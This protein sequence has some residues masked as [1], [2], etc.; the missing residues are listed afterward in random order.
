MVSW[1]E[2]QNRRA[3]ESEIKKW[4]SDFPL[5]NIGIVTGKISNLLVIDVEKGG[6][7]SKFPITDT[8]QTGGGGYHLYYKYC[9][10]VENKTRIYPLTD[11]RGEGGYVVAPPS[12]HASGN[13]YK[14]VK[15]VGRKPFPKE[16][17]PVKRTT[18]W[19]EVM[20]GV[21]QGQRNETIAKITGRLMR[22]IPPRE[23]N[24]IVWPFL[25][26]QNSKNNPPLAESELRNIFISISKRAVNDKREIENQKED[27]QVLPMKE[28]ADFYKD[29]NSSYYKTGIDDFDSALL[30]GFRSGDLVIISGKTGH[31][32]TS[33]AHFLTYNFA[34][35]NIPSLWFSYE[36]FVTELWRKFK[37]MGV[38]DNFVSY[39]PLKNVSGRTD[40]LED[41]IIEA[42]EKY[43]TKIVFIDHLGFLSKK[44]ESTNDAKNYSLY[45]GSICRELKRIAIDFNLV[46]VLMAHTKKTGIETELDN[47]DL[48]HSAG[49]GQEADAV[50]FVKRS[51]EQESNESAIKI[52]KNRRTGKRI[53][54][55]FIFENGFYK[56]K[57]EDKLEKSFEEENW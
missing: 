28:V 57:E 52:T 51:R 33:F 56:K 50:F 11:I 19:I 17:F 42:K 23:W 2:F 12:T 26:W 8:I 40:W 38:S 13:K 7:I 16:M 48:A 53:W 41:K 29:D 3:S 43:G 14:V 34:K 4:W 47:D 49:I 24:P 5:A 18:N 10:G 15:I 22:F 25:Q 6:D 46:V 39:T 35:I 44:M 31:G 1:K 9:E 37:E 30:G 54:L 55:P 36:V 21:N 27:A 20:D 32:K 45:L